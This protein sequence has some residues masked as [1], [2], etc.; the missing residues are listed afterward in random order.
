MKQYNLLIVDDDKT[1]CESIHYH[2]SDMGW[3]VHVAHRGDDALR[4]CSNKKIVASNCLG[5]L[6]PEL[7]KEWHPTKNGKLTLTILFS[8]YNFCSSLATSSVPS[9]LLSSTMI[10]S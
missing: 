10:T 3:S 5:T 2:F 8:P 9:G 1:L 7:A 4:I 6:N